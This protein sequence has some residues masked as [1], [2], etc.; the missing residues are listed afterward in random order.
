MAISRQRPK[1]AQGT[2]EK[3]L[4]ELFSMWSAP[5]PLLVNGSLNP[6]P[7]KQRHATIEHILL[8]NARNTQKQW[9][10]YVSVQRAVNTTIEEEVFSM[11]F[12][13]IHCWAKDV[14]SMG[15]PRDYV[16]GTEPNEIR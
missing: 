10:I 3:V 12:A 6:Y 15:P 13:Y 5:C 1:Y 4:L 14:Y 8:G 7:Q 16:S 9:I 2:T 11:W